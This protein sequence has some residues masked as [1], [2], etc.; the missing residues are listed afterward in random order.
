M[1]MAKMVLG[2]N[3]SGTGMSSHRQMASVTFI[4]KFASVSEFHIHNADDRK[5]RKPFLFA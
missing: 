4:L 5:V 1:V 3:G 2:R